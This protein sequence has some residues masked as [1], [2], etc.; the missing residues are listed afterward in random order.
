MRDRIAIEGDMNT[1]R[2]GRSRDGGNEVEDGVPN[3]D[4]RGL[5]DDKS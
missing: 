2:R 5:F 1:G 3:V 4:V